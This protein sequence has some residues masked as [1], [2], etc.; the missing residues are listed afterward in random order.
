[1]FKKLIKNQQESPLSAFCYHRVFFLSHLIYLSFKRAKE[2]Q[3]F[4]SKNLTFDSFFV[5]LFV[6]L[7]EDSVLFNEDFVE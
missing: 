2:D 1:M 4:P 5:G 7:E 6:G 3:G